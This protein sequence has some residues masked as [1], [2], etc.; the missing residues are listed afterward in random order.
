MG[1]TQSFDMANGKAFFLS[2]M[3]ERALEFSKGRVAHFLLLISITLL[4]LILRFYKLGEWSFWGDELISVRRVSEMVGLN[5]IQTPISR[6]LIALSLSLFGTSEWSARL[7]PAIVGVITV[8]ILYFLVRNIFGHSVGLISSL[9]L[10]L[11]SWHLYW[12]QNVRFYTTIL[13]FYTIALV[14]FY[15]GLEKNRPW[16]LVLSMLFLGLAVRERVFALVFVPI[17]VGY[18]VALMV[19]RFEK[20]PGLRLGNLLLLIIPSVIVGLFFSWRFIQDP[21]QW[22]QTFAWVNNNPLWI[23]SGSVFYLTIPTMVMGAVGGAY[24]LFKK[25]R[26]ALLFSIAALV[27]LFA[28]LAL[29][30]IQYTANRYVFISLTSWLV[31]ASV[32]VRELFTQTRGLSRILAAGTLL[33]LVLEPLSENILYYQYQHGNRDNWKAAFTYIEHNREPD[34]RVAV[35]NNMQGAYYLKE[36]T[37]N[38]DQIDFGNLE[39]SSQ[40]IWFVED[41]TL[42]ELNPRALQWILD[43]TVL[44]ANFDVHVRARNFKMRVYLYEPHGP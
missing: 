6:I 34:D 16:Y 25:D 29:S 12:S 14:A 13:L 19:L 4:A 24:L 3:K 35:F 15:Y 27:P 33:I 22:S 2:T 42:G 1:N 9:F 7:A 44:K 10:A 38:I 43:N 21:S 39:T 40:R 32:G 31:L 37:L 11:S 36:K 18:L 28:I 41:M 30:Y 8:P 26:A 20:P 23:L 17:V 5:L